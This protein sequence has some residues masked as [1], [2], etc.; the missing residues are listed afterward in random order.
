MHV[1]TYVAFLLLDKI[2]W[3]ETTQRTKVYFGSQFHRAYSMS[4]Q[5]MPGSRN[6][7][8]AWQLGSRERKESGTRL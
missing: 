7:R 3:L 2:P 8:P 1:H 5:R 4:W 6:L